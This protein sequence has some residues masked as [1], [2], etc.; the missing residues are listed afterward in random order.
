LQ[1]DKEGIHS[2]EGLDAAICVISLKTRELQFAGAKLSL[3]M[4]RDNTLEKIKG[5]RKSLG[6][7]VTVTDQNFTLHT[8]QSN[9]NTCFYITT[10]GFTDQLGDLRPGRFGSR[11]FSDLLVKHHNQSFE[12]QKKIILGELNRHRGNQ[13]F[14]DDIT[15]VGFKL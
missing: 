11:R 8:L 1:Q 2:D 12:D 3:Y 14:T 4:I 6:Y 15:V 13:S 5:D 9:D 10:D 7:G